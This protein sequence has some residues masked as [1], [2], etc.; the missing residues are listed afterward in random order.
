MTEEKKKIFIGIPC[1]GEVAPEVLQDYI[2]FS[3][4]LG[5]RYQE[6]DFILG[7]KTKSEQ[8]RA[9]N[10][11]VE[12]AYQTGC[13]YLLMLDDDHI[14]DI[15]D[16]KGQSDR[17]EFL[18]RLLIHDKDVIG[19][20]YYQRGGNC[21]PVVMHEAER[22]GYR[23]LRDDEITHGL[24]KVDVTGGGCMLIKMA[25]FDKLSSPWFEAEKE[26]GTDVQICKKAKAVGFEV[27]CDTSIEIGHAVQQRN[28][29]T[30][31]NRHLFTRLED[32]RPESM[33]ISREVSKIMEEYR[34]DAME[35]LG[36]DNLTDV[37]NL[38]LT[39][40][41]HKERFGEFLDKD[42]YYR[43]SGKSYLARQIV[44]HSPAIEHRFCEWIYQSLKRDLPGYGLDFGCGSAPLTFEYARSGHILHFVDIDGATPYEF[45]KWRAKKYGLDG[46][47]ARFHWPDPMSCDYVIMLDSTEHL[48]DWK[49]VLLRC[50]SVLKPLGIVISNF[51]LNEDK[52][53]NEHV[54][55]D[56]PEFLKF[57][58]T[59]G[60]YPI[61]TVVFQRREDIL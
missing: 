49:G 24:Q 11:I 21:H 28:I 17:Y 59:I 38:A 30:G 20:L 52:N 22:G 45:L 23:F 32:N 29:V 40:G 16:T 6:Y 41:A 35:Y 50:K 14:L 3:Y 46:T 5:R 8:F 7:I 9:R 2:R 60:L 56:K 13:Q 55:M 43:S 26:Y 10:A 18:R 25:V 51:M 4:H 42:E 19:A 1:Y 31:K 15:D 54:F 36:I 34:N 61:N 58:A 44:I 39:Y 53:N 37:T 33:S 27:W 57:M 12:G 47:Y 48:E